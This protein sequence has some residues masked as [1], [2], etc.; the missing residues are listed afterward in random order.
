MTGSGAA[1]LP[2]S[3]KGT[4]WERDPVRAGRL[5]AAGAGQR[6]APA[7]GVVRQA[8]SPT[9]WAATW[10][11]PRPT[12]SIACHDLLLAHK[13]ALFDHLVDRWR[14]LFNASFDVLLYDLTSTYFESDPPL[15][16][17][18]QAPLR[19]L[20]RPPARLRASRHR[21]GGDAG[22][23]AAGLRGDG[24]QHGRQHD[25][26]RLP[27]QDRARSTARPGGSG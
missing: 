3:R 5:P 14:D 23:P 16:E 9:C 26:A 22:R 18:R 11:S 7:S 24:R 20:A 25:A 21:A 6:V 10:A 17:G 1:R 15:D 13:Q 8:R 2:A 27:G 4:R 12:S 19:L